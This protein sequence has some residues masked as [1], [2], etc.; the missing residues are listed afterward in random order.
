M[1]DATFNTLVNR[2]LLAL[3]WGG[4]AAAHR[5]AR[6]AERKL[7]FANGSIRIETLLESIP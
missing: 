4:T 2:V 5:A 3:L 1:N 6:R 7:G